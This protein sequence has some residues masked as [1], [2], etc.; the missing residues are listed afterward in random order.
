MSSSHLNTKYMCVCVSDRKR[1][2]E[3]GSCVRTI[4]EV[5]FFIPVD[6]SGVAGAAVADIDVPKATS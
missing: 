6:P 5:A 3:T 4:K 1:N 2:C